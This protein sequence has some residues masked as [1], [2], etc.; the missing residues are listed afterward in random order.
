MIDALD[1]VMSLKLYVTITC[2]VDDVSIEAAATDKFVKSHVVQAVNK[3]TSVI[4]DAGMQF[5]ATKN[6][7]SASSSGLAQHICKQ[8]YH[9]EVKPQSR[10]V[11]LGSPLGA[12]R[13]RHAK[14]ARQLLA[15]F[16]A[17]KGRFRIL[18]KAKLNPTRIFRTG[19]IAALTFGQETIGGCL[20]ACFTNRECL[21]LRQWS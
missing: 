3:F 1:Q 15:K 2:F 14:V 7:V 8:L 6:V 16:K 5:S 21:L 10:V 17:R 4:V 13:W 12:G 20:R 11:S 18:K 19:G 9:T